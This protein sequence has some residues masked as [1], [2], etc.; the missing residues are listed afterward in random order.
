MAIESVLDICSMIISKEDL[1]K[2][3]EYR[4]MILALGQAGILEEEFAEDF[5]QV[6][7]FRNILV[8]QYAEVDLETVYQFLQKRKAQP[9]TRKGQ[10]KIKL[11]CKGPPS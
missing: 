7:G 9:S 11:T 1:K 3:E 8:H 2:P 4:E 5:S 6:A 10:K